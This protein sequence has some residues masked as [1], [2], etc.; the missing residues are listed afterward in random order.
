MLGSIGVMLCSCSLL[1]GDF[2]SRYR[3]NPSVLIE[4][5]VGHIT[6]STNSWQSTFV[7]ETIYSRHTLQTKFVEERNS[8]ID[9]F[10]TL[11]SW[12]PFSFANYPWLKTF[13]IWKV[14]NKYVL[15]EMSVKGLPQSLMRSM[16]PCSRY[17]AFWSQTW[18]YN[19]MTVNKLQMLPLMTASTNDFKRRKEGETRQ[20][21][22]GEEMINNMRFRL[23]YLK[24][25]LIV[26]ADR[27]LERWP[28]LKQTHQTLGL[29]ELE[30]R[31]YDS[32]E[33]FQYCKNFSS[34][35]YRM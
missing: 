16:T 30:T 8:E 35:S 2:S 22:W 23:V 3:L 5:Q 7:W 21:D 11:L 15:K 18:A 1:N 19:I 17:E 27:R 26:E 29:V 13:G 28:T 12:L 34:K 10:V 32:V 14:F 25:N 24:Y 31:E 33:W 4:S 20:Q 9:F 6:A